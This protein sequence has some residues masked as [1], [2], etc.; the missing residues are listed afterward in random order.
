VAFFAR[1]ARLSGAECV[2]KVCVAVA[3]LDVGALGSDV[4]DQLHVALPSD[5]DAKALQ[6]RGAGTCTGACTNKM[7]I[8]KEALVS[9]ATRL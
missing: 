9:D 3:G 2:L 5:E 7:S 4:L 6:A 1:S 8:S